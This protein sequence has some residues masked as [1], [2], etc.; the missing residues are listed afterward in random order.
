MA[1]AS[2]LTSVPDMC[3]SS[4]A[5]GLLGREIVAGGKAQCERGAPSELALHRD[6]AVELLDD[7]LRNGEP[8]AKAAPLGRYE[9]VEDRRQALRRNAGACVGDVDFHGG[10]RA[11]RSNRQPAARR[12]GLYRVGNEVAVHPA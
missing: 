8:K 11:P 5:G 1:I 9:I 12:H 6:R 7:L 4:L 2:V 10:A 3:V